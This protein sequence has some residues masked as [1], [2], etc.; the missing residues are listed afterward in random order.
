M[1]VC[2]KQS[3][4][5]EI[6]DLYSKRSSTYDHSTW[7]ERI[8]KNLVDYAKI[9]NDSRVL[10]IATGTGMVAFYAAS[11][12]GHSGAV[13]GI[14]ISE[15]MI[16]T[17][18]AKLAKTKL[19]NIS[20][21]I[22]DGETLNYVPDSFDI[23]FCGSAFIWMADLL[24]TLIHWKTRLRPGGQVGFHAFSEKAFV[25]GAVAQTVLQRYGID[26]QMNK[27]TGTIEKCHKLLDAAG[28]KNISIKVDK[29]GSF[30]SLENAK[31]SWFGTSHPAP[32]QYPHPLKDLPPEVLA[33]ARADY[34]AEIESLNTDEGVWSDMTTFYVYAE[35]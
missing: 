23:I 7:H 9:K 14:D 18:K 13:V 26:Y 6:A 16:D 33:N 34:E 2:D 24:A 25:T 28:F 12:I 3:Y 19:Q 15:G 27:P 5:K 1:N 4:K 10:D 8:A 32:G 20:F 21:A 30:M 22:G 11:K 17:A 29:D 31:N 35:K